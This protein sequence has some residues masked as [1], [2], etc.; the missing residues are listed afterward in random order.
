[1]GCLEADLE[2]M[3]IFIVQRRISVYS[4]KKRVL[5]EARKVTEIA[6]GNPDDVMRPAGVYDGKKYLPGGLRLLL[7]KVAQG[8]GMSAR[9]VAGEM[10]AREKFFGMQRMQRGF[11]DAF[12]EIQAHLFGGVEGTSRQGGAGRGRKQ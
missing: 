1:M 3:E 12:S 6:V 10:K 5:A 2:G 8:T 4:A 11:E 7:G 9:E